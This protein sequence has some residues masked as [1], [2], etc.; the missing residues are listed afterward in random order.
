MKMTD[1]KTD[2][3]KTLDAY[4][5]Q[6]GRFRMVDV[7]EMQYV[8]IDGHGDPN[9]SPAFVEAIEAL[10]PVAYK[11]KFAS[12]RNLGR[13]YVVPPL[14]GLWWA[15]DMRSFTTARDKSRWDWTLMLMVPDWIDE[16][17]FSS[18]VEQAAAR[19]RPARLDDVRL[20]TLA[21]GRCVQTLHVGSFDDEADVLARLHH[22]FIPGH[23]L[24]MA[25]THHEIYLSDFRKVAPDKRRT[26]LR[27][28]VTTD[29]RG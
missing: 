25:G 28:P 26:I 22:E 1:D 11:L 23:R 18:A 6:R 5:A 7:P 13:D 4:Q 19:H 10:Y 14:E 16:R 24:R 21:E 8:M 17:M 2:F 29:T 9:T 27:Q 12:K 3:K 15:A 20:Q